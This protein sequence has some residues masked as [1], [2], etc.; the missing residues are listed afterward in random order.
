MLEFDSMSTSR[1]LT[2]FFAS[3][4]LVGS[5]IGAAQPSKSVNDGVFTAE[6]AVRGEQIFKAKCGSCHYPNRFTGDDLFRPWAGKPLA[7]LFSVMRESMPE[8]NPGTLPAQEYGDVVAYIL[9]LNKFPT[10]A[11]ELVATD[12]AMAAILFERPK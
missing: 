6:Q 5:V 8:D 7:E 9:Q 10:G 4:V 11:D 3:L 1:F 12:E 2:A